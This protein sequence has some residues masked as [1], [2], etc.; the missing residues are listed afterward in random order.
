MTGKGL[1]VVISAPSGGGKTTIIRKVLE[2]G[3]GD[4]RYSVSATTRPRRPNE[5]DGRD[6]HFM[7]PDTF[8]E[9]EKRGQFIE[10]AEVHG[11]YYATPKTQLDRWLEEGK[12][13]FLDLDVQGGLEVKKRY[14]DA[15]LLI[16]VKPPSRES[17]AERLRRRNT[18]D[19]Q[20]IERRLRRYP[21]EMKMAERYDYQV[22]NKD[23]DATVRQVL[24]LLRKR[25]RE[26]HSF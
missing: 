6:Y 8:R 11:Y 18:E 21:E 13:V 20:E 12:I 19:A 4:F 10:C 9:N 7:D 22:V 2:S 25:K 17:L 16:F 5:V 3:N 15:A 1:L 14:G 26:L 23:L 24:D